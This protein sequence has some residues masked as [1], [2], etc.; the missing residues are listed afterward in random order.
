VKGTARGLGCEEIPGLP[1]SVSVEVDKAYRFGVVLMNRM[2]RLAL[3]TA[4]ALTLAASVTGPAH[5]AAPSNDGPGRAKVATGVGY[6]DSV[7]V[8][9]ATS[10]RRDPTNCANNASVWYEYTAGTTERINVNTSGSNYDTVIG[11]YTGTRD[12][13]TRVRCVDDDFTFQAGLDLEVEA[14]TTY[15]F[16][17]AACCGNGRDG[18]DYRQP[19]RLQ[20]HMMTPLGIDQ[21]AA[22]DTGIVDRADGEAHVTVSHQCNHVARGFWDARLLQRVGA[23]FVAKG[24]SFPRSTCGTSTSDLT[25]TFEPGGDVAFDEGPA[26]VT[27]R[28]DACS[29]ETGTCTRRRIAEEVVLAYP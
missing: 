28:L 24:F 22:A 29:R 27:I 14:G 21:L 2:H 10:G 26:S 11:V 4:V 5:A 7:N 19:L 15:Y 12:A 20:F 6:T 18:Q 25:L 16:M 17:V 9:Q 3:I 13:L 8:S 23:T 1:T